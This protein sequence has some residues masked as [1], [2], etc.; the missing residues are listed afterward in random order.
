M[1]MFDSLKARKAL[2][3]HRK[4]DIA[5]ARAALTS[6]PWCDASPADRAAA[7]PGTLREAID[8][9]DMVIQYVN[10]GSG[11]KDLIDRAR[12]RLEEALKTL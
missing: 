7:L 10:D 4:G 9:A 1:G 6:S 8:F 3:A 11:T 12:T 5:A 2:I